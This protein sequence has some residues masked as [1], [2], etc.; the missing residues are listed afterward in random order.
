MKHKKSLSA[1]SCFFFG[2]TV[3]HLQ[4]S[5]VNAQNGVENLPDHPAAIENS[6]LYVL[7]YL[8]EV[9]NEAMD[10]EFDCGPTFIPLMQRFVDTIPTTFTKKL[11]KDRIFCKG[12]NP[13]DR[14]G[15]FDLRHRKKPM[16]TEATG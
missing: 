16:K 14:P 6:S 10:Q 13:F 12:E 2:A 8:Q 7:K 5:I 4:C 3:E 11:Q 1:V 9:I 15:C